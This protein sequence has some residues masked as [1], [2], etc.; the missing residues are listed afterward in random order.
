MVV[1]FIPGDFSGRTSSMCFKY[2]ANKFR[3]EKLKTD[4]RHIREGKHGGA[5]KERVQHTRP[6]S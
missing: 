2:L 5:S 6:A 4:D 3:K 1:S